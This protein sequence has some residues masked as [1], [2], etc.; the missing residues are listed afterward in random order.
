[1][2]KSNSFEDLIVW[3]KSIDLSVEKIHK[4][5]ADFP[6]SEMFGLTAR[7][8]NASNFVSLNISK[9]SARTT[10]MFVN[11]LIIAKGSANE[12]LSGSILAVRPGFMAYEN[13]GKVRLMTG[14]V[15]KMLRGLISSL[16]KQN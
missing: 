16:E 1:M 4:I 3:Q 2:E 15:V 8:R 14:E 6:K 12:V 9:G 13:L 10:R 7:I 11:Q 5:T